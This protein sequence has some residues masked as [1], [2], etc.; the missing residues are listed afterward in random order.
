MNTLPAA[1]RPGDTPESGADLGFSS[2]ITG[3]TLFSKHIGIS[4]KPNANAI[5]GNYTDIGIQVTYDFI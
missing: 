3:T 2:G 4:L 1:F 5:H